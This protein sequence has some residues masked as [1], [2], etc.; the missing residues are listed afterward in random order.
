[1]CCEVRR[2]R[3]TS[4]RTPPNSAAKVG[5]SAGGEIKH[6]TLAAE[7]TGGQRRLK[8]LGAS[9]VL[10]GGKS[11]TCWVKVKRREETSPATCDVNHV[12][13]EKE[14]RAWKKRGNPETPVTCQRQESGETGKRNLG[15]LGGGVESIREK[16]LGDKGRTRRGTWN[17]TNG[18]GGE[19]VVG[20]DRRKGGN[21]KGVKQLQP[22]NIGER[23]TR[24]S[25]W[26]PAFAEKKNFTAKK[27]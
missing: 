20:R 4:E 17:R 26:L 23:K 7:I 2:G 14:K 18:G 8:K 19:T 11:F 21:T 25:R 16:I 13:R 9:L 24:R 12:G 10:L 6:L 22:K 27:R 15:S 1:M 5:G 3:V